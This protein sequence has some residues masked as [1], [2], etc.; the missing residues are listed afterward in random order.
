MRSNMPGRARQKGVAAVEFA[1]MLIPMLLL[2]FGVVEYGRALYQYN[3][4]VKTVRDGVRLLSQSNP[5][6][7]SYADRM[8]A[9]QCLIVYGK[10]A[11]SGADV[12]L[13]PGLSTGHVRICDRV[14]Y[15][16]CPSAAQ[17]DYLNVAT[18]MGVVNLVEV[19]VTGYT[20]TFLGL[21]FAVDADSVVFGDIRAVM[22]QV[23]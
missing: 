14:H 22:R 8:A 12:P 16:A 9:A 4:L 21:P 23:A 1:L 11:C 10:T 18:G 15:A 3:T 2:A 5:A 20:F 17:S 7:E 19:R 13:V 6:D